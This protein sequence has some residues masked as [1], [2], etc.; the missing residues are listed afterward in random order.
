MGECLGRTLDSTMAECR[1]TGRA[2]G[3][4][5][6]PFSPRDLRQT[7]SPSHVLVSPSVNVGDCMAYGEDAS[8]DAVC[9]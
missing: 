3:L 9:P 5:I 8:A 6:L 1:V 2:L 4:K 7:P